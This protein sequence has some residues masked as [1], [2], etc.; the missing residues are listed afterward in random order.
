ML[1]HPVTGEAK[2][3][4]QYR[5]VDGVAQR[6]P[7]R[8]PLRD[9]RLIEHAEVQCGSVGIRGHVFGITQL[10]GAWA[11]VGQGNIMQPVKP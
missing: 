2:S 4:G 9:G 10:M 11:L 3:V 1:G 7:C 6:V 5:K 8:H